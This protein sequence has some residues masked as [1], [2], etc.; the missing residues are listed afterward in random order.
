VTRG[1]ADNGVMVLVA[2]AGTENPAAEQRDR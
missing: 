1:Q 2:Y